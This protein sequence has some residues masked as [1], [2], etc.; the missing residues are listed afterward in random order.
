MTLTSFE[1]FRILIRSSTKSVPRTSVNSF[2]VFGSLLISRRSI[3]STGRNSWLKRDLG[4][5]QWMTRSRK[6][7]VVL[8]SLK[9]RNSEFYI[10][11]KWDLCSMVR[12]ME[13][14]E[15]LVRFSMFLNLLMA[16]SLSKNPVIESQSLSQLTMEMRFSLY[17][18]WYHP[19]QK[20]P[21]LTKIWWW[22]CIKSLENLDTLQSEASIVML[23]SLMI[24]MLLVVQNI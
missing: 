21:I 3:M 14:V 11:M 5:H 16:V 2:G 17:F 15:D 8:F 4:E 1:E 9:A 12:R 7:M 22:T 24:V 10:L 23:V 6:N 19:M 13:L 20:N 18:L